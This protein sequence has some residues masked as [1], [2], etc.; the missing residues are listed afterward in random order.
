MADTTKTEDVLKSS[1][2]EVEG[3]EGLEELEKKFQAISA[4]AEVAVAP[5]AR[6][7]LLADQKAELE[8]LLARIEKG[9]QVLKTKVTGDLNSLKSLKETVEQELAKVKSLESTKSKVETEIEKV[10]EL[11]KNEAS[12]AEEIKDLGKEIE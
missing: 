10:A 2:I 6:A 1:G 7:S 11:E 12:L 8:K 9:L 4:P 5:A 3:A